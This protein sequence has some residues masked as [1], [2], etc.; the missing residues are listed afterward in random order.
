MNI[1]SVQYKSKLKLLNKFN[2]DLCVALNTSAQSTATH[3]YTSMKSV[4]LH[5][6]STVKFLRYTSHTDVH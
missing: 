1:K 4:S 3:T 2:R 5:V 6:D